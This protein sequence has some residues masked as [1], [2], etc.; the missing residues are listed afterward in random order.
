MNCDIERTRQDTAGQQRTGLPCHRL[1]YLLFEHLISPFAAA[2][3]E[4]SCACT[5]VMGV[6]RQASWKNLTPPDR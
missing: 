5:D 3:R 1:R 4:A 2:R 6:H